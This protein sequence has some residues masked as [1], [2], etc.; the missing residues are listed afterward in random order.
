MAFTF[1]GAAYDDPPV[2]ERRYRV[3]PRG[4]STM[5]GDRERVQQQMAAQQLERQRR[6]MADQL[7]PPQQHPGL[8]DVDLTE[9]PPANVIPYT[10]VLKQR[11]ERLERENARLRRLAEVRDDM[12]TLEQW[13]ARANTRLRWAQILIDEGP[14]FD[15]RSYI[16]DALGS[17]KD[18]LAFLRPARTEAALDCGD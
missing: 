11:L 6:G 16:A 8:V 3:P 9:P 7:R 15:G 14:H 12:P 13:R 18:A 2:D 4:V 10:R 17:L 5:F 1:G